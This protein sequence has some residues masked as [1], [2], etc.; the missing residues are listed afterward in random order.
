M[1]QDTALLHVYNLLVVKGLK[2]FFSAFYQELQVEKPDDF[3]KISITDL[4]NIGIV[5]SLNIKKFENIILE[6]QQHTTSKN[7]NY[8]Q[9]N[10]NSFVVDLMLLN[11]DPVVI[12]SNEISCNEVLGSGN[13]GKVFKGTWFK[14]NHTNKA[15][16][17]PV[18][19]K[20]LAD[21]AEMSWKKEVSIFTA[22]NQ[23]HPNILKFYGLLIG[24]QDEV[25]MVTEFAACGSLLHGLKARNITSIAILA[26]FAVQ[27]ATGMVFLHS[28]NLVHRD[29]SARNILVTA[30]NQVKISDFGLSKI[31]DDT[32]NEWVMESNEMLPMRWLAPES[33][34]NGI[35]TMDSDVWSFAVVLWEM[36]TFGDLPWSEYNNEQ[37]KDKIQAGIPLRE[38]NVCPH[39]FY[40][41]MLMCFCF[42]PDE[43][44]PFHIIRDEL[45]AQQPDTVLTA[46]EQSGYHVLN[47]KKNEY[48]TA[49]KP[50][51]ETD[52]DLWLGQHEAS[53]LFGC[54]SLTSTD[55]IDFNLP[56]DQNT[57]DLQN[58]VEEVNIPADQSL[59]SP[60]ST[61]DD[62]REEP[63]YQLAT[64]ALSYVETTRTRSES[65]P[66]VSITTQDENFS[67]S[68]DT[69]EAA[70]RMKALRS[71]EQPRLRPQS[72]D[73]SLNQTER[74]ECQ[75]KYIVHS[76]KSDSDSKLIFKD[77]NPVVQETVNDRIS[78]N[79][80]AFLTAVEK[81]DN[82]GVSPKEEQ[83]LVPV[84]VSIAPSLDHIINSVD[85][86]PRLKALSQENI[87]E[88][89]PNVKQT[90]I[91]ERC[92]SSENLIQ[93]LAKRPRPKANTKRPINVEKQS[94]NASCV[95]QDVRHTASSSYGVHEK[96]PKGLT[97]RELYTKDIS[98][99]TF[100]SDK[101]N[102]TP[103]CYRNG[104]MCRVNKA[105]EHDQWIQK[106][107]HIDSMTCLAKRQ[108]KHLSSDLVDGKTS[109]ISSAKEKTKSTVTK[110]QSNDWHV[111]E[112]STQ[113][114]KKVHK[115]RRKG[116]DRKIH[117]TSWP[118][119]MSKMS[120][121]MKEEFSGK[122][123]KI[124]TLLPTANVT[125]CLEGLRY[126][127]NNVEKAVQYIQ[128]VKLTRAN[129]GYSFEHCLKIF[130]KHNENYTE[131]EK[132]LKLQ[133][134]WEQF[135]YLDREQVRE[136]LVINKWDIKRTLT[137]VFIQNCVEIGVNEKE[138]ISIFLECDED[139]AKSLEMAKIVRL[140]EITNKPEH[141]C[142]RVLTQ[143]SWK[144]ENAVDSIYA[145]T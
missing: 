72:A 28:K 98:H 62:I 92:H 44:P 96:L 76:L 54:F 132:S 12:C 6:V 56:L 90:K 108:H 32:T 8:E 143:C 50:I 3:L 69:H 38:P 16:Q 7:A 124:K 20:T 53:L 25:K 79:M 95:K 35:F 145:S 123:K 87:Y 73:F 105:F 88:D 17:V 59:E 27:I 144:L 39:G 139:V 110:Y 86:Y 31:L 141:T 117:E 119:D 68:R 81:S 99:A 4:Y 94:Q 77:T 104:P 42:D 107:D 23:N 11:Q 97:K 34:N 71:D 125:E 111:F 65:Q 126:C 70:T 127:G 106:S 133:F 82:I 120:R 37:V 114:P 18:A 118:S 26:Q 138:A 122:F 136:L 78:R 61:V 13:F 55:V 36:F 100:L 129:F 91:S 113:D 85:P 15:L 21:G 142:F 30:K 67:I 74:K 10:D 93:G 19:V 9:D 48:V 137:T 64:N 45:I 14:K 84:N 130:Q 112:N 5:S 101:E 66:V 121:E 46:A 102:L 115:I 80:K 40:D 29:L 22:L 2:A 140:A 135:K 51:S 128:V 131:A 83:Y 109:A 24:E 89:T 41:I 47:F 63:S 134:V 60:H 103:S 116:S 75:E 58:K 43:R 1:V 33:F 49:I 52:V 57:N